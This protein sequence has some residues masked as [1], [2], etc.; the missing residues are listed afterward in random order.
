MTKATQLN[1]FTLFGNIHSGNLHILQD[2][3]EEESQMCLGE[4][5]NEG[6]EVTVKQM[7]RLIADTGI[8]HPN[9]RGHV[10]AKSQ[11]L[12]PPRPYS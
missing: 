3:G 9:P 6:R 11:Y 12:T 4:Q 8:E 7:R 1:F 5:N 10:R 2:Q